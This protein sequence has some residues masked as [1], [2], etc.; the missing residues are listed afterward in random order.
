[1]MSPK[2]VTVKREPVAVM[3]RDRAEV[4]SPMLSTVIAPLPVTRMASALAALPP[5]VSMSPRFVTITGETSTFVA[6]TPPRSESMLPVVVTLL[7]PGPL[8]WAQIP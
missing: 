7:V 8:P 6:R 1:M 4:K 2:L 3:P 5:V